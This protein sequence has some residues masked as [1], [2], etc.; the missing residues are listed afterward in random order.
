MV[1][2]PP[3]VVEIVLHNIYTWIDRTVLTRRGVVGRRKWLAAALRVAHAWAQAGTALLYREIDVDPDDEDSA[4]LVVFL[5]RTLSVSPAL[6]ALVQT[7][8]ILEP[9]YVRRRLPIYNR[10]FNQKR[11]DAHTKRLDDQRTIS[12]SNIRKLQ[13]L[14]LNLKTVYI[15]GTCT[16]N[17]NE[18]ALPS[19][20]LLE[21]VSV[22]VMMAYGETNFMFKELARVAPQLRTLHIG[23]NDDGFNHFPQ[24]EER[25]PVF[26]LLSVSLWKATLSKLTR[27]ELV[28]HIDVAMLAELVQAVQDTVQAIRVGIVMESGSPRL[29]APVEWLQPVAD[30]LKELHLMDNCNIS[31]Q[32]LSYMTAL[33]KLTVEVRAWNYLRARPKL[34][35]Q[36]WSAVFF[37]IIPQNFPPNVDS[38]TWTFPLGLNSPW[39]AAQ[40]AYSTLAA[41]DK[42]PAQRH[43]D[44]LYR[45]LDRWRW[46]G[47][48]VRDAARRRR[49][50]PELCVRVL[51]DRCYFPST[52]GPGPLDSFARHE[53]ENQMN[54]A[55]SKKKEEDVSAWKKLTTGL[56]ALGTS[57][58]KTAKS[59]EE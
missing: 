29:P 11:F 51:F 19:H 55:G 52:T 30:R 9:G 56:R 42:V 13:L 16:E 18:Q 26:T 3:E 6:A 46:I 35:A 5:I 20:N 23:H 58:S 39:D 53:M 15:T 21:H 34:M 31:V 48:L 37:P 24:A 36:R 33:E 25:V 17:L 41:V 47:L 1:H 45:D 38:I 49:V 4:Q 54:H 43:P 27:L 2:L 50:L 59:S 14:C 32:D 44:E 40:R 8:R 7:L 57:S 28:I 22:D 10:D 12:R